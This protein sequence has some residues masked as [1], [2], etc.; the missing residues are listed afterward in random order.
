[1]TGKNLTTVFGLGT[2][3][4]VL[5]LTASTLLTGKIEKLLWESQP[6]PEII[7]LADASERVAFEQT[8]TIYTQR[9]YPAF[10]RLKVKPTHNNPDGFLCSGTVISNKYVLTAG[11]CLL[12]DKGF[13]RKDVEIESLQARNIDD[14][15]VDLQT[16]MPI[17]INMRADYGL[18]KGDFLEYDQMKIDASPDFQNNVKSSPVTCGFPWGSKKWT[19]YGTGGVVFE[20]SV[21]VVQ[22][23]LYPGMSGGPVIDMERNTVIAINSATMPQGYIR[24]T[25][26]VGLFETMGVENRD[27]Q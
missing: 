26:L 9:I 16:A 3:C 18:I 27:E 13:L 17:G 10:V 14:P 25:P 1:M 8:E 21:L 15:Q 20:H 6:R 2:L 23:L 22:G 12:D 19:C 24:I 11:H 4:M 5:A 7:Q